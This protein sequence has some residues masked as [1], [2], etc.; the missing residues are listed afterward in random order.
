MI[1]TNASMAEVNKLLE[2]INSTFY[3]KDLRII[4]LRRFG[5]VI[6]AC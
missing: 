1:V 5:L 2:N 4:T 3:I 6:E